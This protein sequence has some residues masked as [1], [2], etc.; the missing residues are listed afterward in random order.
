MP[1]GRPPSVRHLLFLS[2][3]VA[4]RLQSEP[5]RDHHHHSALQDGYVAESVP[6]VDEQWRTAVGQQL[7][8]D[9]RVK[10][11][12][13]KNTN[14]EA[15]IVDNNENQNI[16]RNTKNNKKARGSTQ[17][18]ALATVSPAES[19]DA[20]VRAPPAQWSSAQSS[21]GLAS[22]HPARSLQD[23]QVEDIILLATVDGKLHARDR[24]TGAPRWELDTSDMVQ[25]I[26]HPHNKTYTEDGQEV[27][28]A[29]FVVE[30]IEDGA[31]YAIIP[32]A[33]LTKLAHTVKELSE[34][35]PWEE[36][37]PLAVTYTSEK[38][39][40]YYHIDAK[41]GRI[42]KSFL[43]GGSY[44]NED[45]CRL[46]SP[47]DDDNECKTHGTI[48]LGRT[49]YTVGIHSTRTG[50]ALE[51]LKYS[52]WAPNNRDNDLRSRY[53]RTMDGKYVYTRWNGR[54]TGFSEAHAKPD[55]TQVFS[56][57][58]VR[59]F[60]LVRPKADLSQDAYLLA[61]P[62]PI[63]PPRNSFA[64]LDDDVEFDPVYINRTESGS[65]YAL[66]E[67]QYPSVTD[68]AP[69]LSSL[70][71]GRWAKKDFAGVYNLPIPLVQDEGV[72][73]IDAPPPLQSKSSVSGAMDTPLPTPKRNAFDLTF[74]TT[75]MLGV[76][77]TVAIL[78]GGAI[79]KWPN[80]RDIFFANNAGVQVPMAEVANVSTGEEQPVRRIDEPAEELIFPKPANDEE[81]PAP[82]RVHF[83]VPVETDALQK[84]PGDEAKDGE[85]KPKKKATRGRRGGRKQKEKEQW[86]ADARAAKKND[87]PL[88]T[89]SPGFPIIGA[90]TQ[91]SSIANK[92]L[93]SVTQS[94]SPDMSG[95]FTIHNLTIDPNKEIG[96][97]SGGTIVFEGHFEGR[98]VAVKRMLV[99]YYDLAEL[100]VSF[101][102][103]SDGHTN[104]VR[105][106]CREK[107]EN[108]LYIAVELC[109][110]SLFDVWEADK[111]KTEEQRAIRSKLKL[112]IQKDMKRSL[113]QLAAG[114]AHLHKLRIL[115]RDIKPQNILVAY[116][117]PAQ[118]PGT[119]RLVISDFGLGK[120]LP[121]NMSTLID[122][123]GNVGTSGWK[124]PELI[125]H[126]GEKTESNHS[127]G[128][129]SHSAQAFQGDK[130]E[131]RCV[132][133]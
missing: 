121:E 21:A 5:K 34:I 66:S 52:E 45:S 3:L 132:D 127:R 83:D 111:A 103:K 62:Q 15:E 50:E 31:M 7:N 18:S 119:T 14:V 53:E 42:R 41:T 87:S 51:T 1:P 75:F 60:D 11:K 108:F 10:H 69:V 94:E 20:A 71:A 82:A 48:T 86:Q 101:L 25:V 29:H 57:P 38:R 89:E 84:E 78:G 76:M 124:A 116:P 44:V 88:E 81:P 70:D 120:N 117:G 131:Y 8:Q 106:F 107:D 47:L 80:A 109:Q 67:K 35:T 90:T 113:H 6:A 63:P 23:W 130:L 85:T 77:C 56:S 2:L 28:E 97:G 74:L 125:T 24:G 32:D 68:G 93:I 33:G 98:K 65:W 30:P 129:F 118:P 95:P 13:Q 39:T 17:Q 19:N 114:L 43:P 55:F 79:Y 100:E 12:A 36:T 16:N 105:Y 92:Q 126:P 73:L 40:T 122:P 128:K 99:Q 22:R 58:V 72:P 46:V 26:T 123:T 4:A 27:P 64:G 102:H 61:L 91:L 59:V 54:I 112:E 9:L 110:S 96:R 37:G 115:H 104:V 49:E 133:R